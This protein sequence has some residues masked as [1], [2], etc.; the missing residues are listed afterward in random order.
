MPGG[1]FV[2]TPAGSL[3]I[4]KLDSGKWVE[5][6]VTA[7]AQKWAQTPTANNGALVKLSNE[8]KLHQVSSCQPRVLGRDCSAGAGGRLRRRCHKP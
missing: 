4:T 1:D 7:L 8:T 6:D 3:A 5:V 2:A